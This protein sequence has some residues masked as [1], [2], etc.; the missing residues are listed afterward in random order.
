MLRNVLSISARLS[1]CGSQFLSALNAFNLLGCSEFFLNCVL[2]SSTS[3]GQ[4]VEIHIGFQDG[5][6]P[7]HVSLFSADSCHRGFCLF[8]VQCLC[9]CRWPVPS[10]D[11]SLSC[12][13]SH[14]FEPHNEGKTPYGRH[15]HSISCRFQFVNIISN[16]ITFT[17]IKLIEV[18]FTLL[19]LTC[20]W[21]SKQLGP[22]DKRVYTFGL[23]SH[24]F[25]CT[26]QSNKLN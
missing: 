23:S 7:S 4:M 9:F 10:V 8:T 25:L 17:D 22:S 21:I 13:H 18:A 11:V 16:D 1:Y 15:T 26:F 3:D 14:S 6:K 5:A 12:R 24:D 2:N 20:G 19:M